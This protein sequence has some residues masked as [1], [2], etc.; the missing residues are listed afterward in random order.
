MSSALTLSILCRRRK[1]RRSSALT[2]QPP[3]PMRGWLM[4]RARGGR[5]QKSFFFTSGSYL[6]YA[7]SCDADA[8]D[9]VDL[10]GAAS[11]VDAMDGFTLRVVGLSAKD[12]DGAERTLRTL[13]L[14][15]VSSSKDAS[16]S[17]SL[18]DWAVGLREA[19]ET[20][21]LK[22]KFARCIASG[23]ITQTEAVTQQPKT[24]VSD[25]DAPWFTSFMTEVQEL[26]AAPEE[27]VV[28]ELPVLLET[29]PPS[30]SS[31][32]P[33]QAAASNHAMPTAKVPRCP[34]AHHVTAE[35]SRT[36]TVARA[37][38][39][40]S[41]Q[42]LYRVDP[43]TIDGVLLRWFPESASWKLRSFYIGKQAGVDV[44]V[45]RNG[46]HCTSPV[47]MMISLVGSQLNVE[48]LL[49][50]SPTDDSRYVCLRVIGM[51]LDRTD[52]K[53]VS[54]LLRKRR[55]T[56]VPD[57]GPQMSDWQLALQKINRSRPFSI[58]FY[59]ST[60]KG[61]GVSVQTLAARVR[62]ASVE[63]QR[64]TA[65][66]DPLKTSPGAQQIMEK[67]SPA[68]GGR[69]EMSGGGKDS[70]HTESGSDRSRP[71]RQKKEHERDAAAEQKHSEP[72]RIRSCFMYWCG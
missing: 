9:G 57:D 17:P 30:P 25:G 8:V 29:L 14:K 56:L 2:L 10:A 64:E 1:V 41:Q 49:S 12:E 7:Y 22:E 59:K 31:L 34:S 58:E 26:A 47:E 68:R 23:V 46:I 67:D 33:P 66:D 65:L 13:Q 61:A 63:L 32:L 4:K 52:S 36:Y 27:R 51:Q 60:T 20:L 15:A 48:S 38:A 72:S 21:R 62:C 16:A 71:P 55:S 3:A 5:W 11:T 42:Q 43:F 40:R 39:T 19:A 54:L 70:G 53:L 69:G 6:M 18:G 44:L 50:F 28:E 45:M 37:A 35:A 24:L